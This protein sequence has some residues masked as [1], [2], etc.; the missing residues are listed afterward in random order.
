M[1]PCTAPPPRRA[2]AFRRRRRS[3]RMLGQSHRPSS[4]WCCSCPMPTSPLRA[5]AWPRPTRRA[6]RIARW[7]ACA[8]RRGRHERG[9]AVPV[10]RAAGAR[11]RHAM[12][13]GINVDPASQGRGIGSLHDARAHATTPTLAGPGKA[14]RAHRLGRQRA[15]ASRCIAGTASRSR[16]GTA[17]TRCATGSTSTPCLMARLHPSPLSGFPRG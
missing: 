11:R 4:R 2:F 8:R 5:S 17:A 12:A 6:S 16:A 3:S 9:R 13:L 15:R 14:H 7:W 1:P 10:G